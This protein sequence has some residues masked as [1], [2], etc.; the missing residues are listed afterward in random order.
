M[1]TESNG[2]HR[3]PERLCLIQLGTPDACYLIDPLVISGMAPLGKLLQDPHVEKIIHSA[4]YDLR[5]L[6]REWGFHLRNL[7][8]TSVAARFAG[9]SKLGLGSVL[10]ELLKVALNK[11]KR[12]QRAD[13]SE[14]PLSAEAL[15]Y[16]ADDVGFLI[17][18]RDQ[19][20]ARVEALG[21]TGWVDEELR[22]LEQIRYE[23]PEPLETAFMS[24][25]GSRLLTPRALAILKAL[26]EMREREALRRN[27][28][29]FRVIPTESLL[30]LAAEPHADLRD[31]PGLTKPVLHRLSNQIRDA[32]LKGLAAPP[33]SRPKGPPVI[34]PTPA[35]QER[36]KKLRDWR[37]E[38]GRALQ[39]D[40]S[41]IW[42]M[43]SLER[44]ARAPRTLAM[45][46]RAP[47]VRRWQV[48]EFGEKLAGFLKGLESR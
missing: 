12:L 35:E 45:E 22:R 34:R 33:I 19:L 42:P 21:R 25:K 2:F 4:D 27:R 44:L 17:P 6:D 3:Y 9:L 37:T 15:A 11:E 40:P 36:L 26:V 39:L 7:Y 14:R 43:L 32:V 20:A 41:V 8:D 46:Q 16:A 47:E 13:W 38:Q 30:F 28:P 23:H 24:I 48:R 5:T 1:D 29:P 18:L 31:V 10:E